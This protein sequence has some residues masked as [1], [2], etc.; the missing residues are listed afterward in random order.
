M[1][2]AIETVTLPS[3]LRQAGGRQ[4]SLSLLDD[5]LNTNGRQNVFELAASVPWRVPSAQR[6]GSTD[7]ETPGFSNGH[8]EEPLADMSQTEPVLDINYAAELSQRSQGTGPHIFG[9]AVIQRGLADN[10]EAAN[11]VDHI[12]S[13]EASTDA[14]VE[15]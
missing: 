15:Q 5:M 6:V 13:G 10:S 1:A 8:A 2:T 14:V 4:A 11:T 7:G 12:V 9:Q 3:R